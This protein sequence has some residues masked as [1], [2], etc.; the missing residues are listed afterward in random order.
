M[1]RPGLPAGVL[2]LVG[3]LGLAGMASHAA[4]PLPD[5]AV[6]SRALQSSPSV[7]AARAGTEEADA[8]AQLLMTGPYEWTV[9]AS[10]QRREVDQEATYREWDTGVERAVRLPAKWRIDRSRARLEP[11]VAH[12]RLAEAVRQERRQIAERWLECIVAHQRVQAAAAAAAE[13]RR[14]QQLL[15]ARHRS[16]DASQVDDDLAL[17]DRAAAELEE[18]TA[19]IELEQA[20][21]AIR[22]FGIEPPAGEVR[23]E[24]LPPAAKAPEPMASPAAR[25][26]RLEADRADAE[27]RRAVADRL[28][29]PTLSL[30]WSSER[31]GAE[32]LATVSV[33]FPLPGARRAADARRAQARSLQAASLAADAQRRERDELLVWQAKL[34]AARSRAMQLEAESVSRRRVAETLTRAFELGD[35]DLWQIAAGRREERRVSG[36]LLLARRDAWLAHAWLQ[37]FSGDETQAL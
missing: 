26:A 17:A 36:A 35:G 32:R 10:T 2:G 7:L 19:R 27:A 4:S 22:L 37:S 9:K 6:V 28:P 5:E 24:G 11:I 33:A 20:A 12:A 31:G 18:A 29:D 25:L 21:A 13:S 8:A 34:L 23:I 1:I 15:T 16:G 30:R 14:L 3:F